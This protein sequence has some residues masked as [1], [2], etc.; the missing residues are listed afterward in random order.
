MADKT[1]IS[2]LEAQKGKELKALQDEWKKQISTKPKIV[3]P[4]DGKKYSPDSYFAYDGFFPGY[5]AQ[6]K[7]VLFI[8]RETRWISGYNFVDTTIDFFKNINVAGSAWWRTILY[9]FYGIQHEGKLSYA[10]IPTA[11]EIAKAMLTTNDFG[12]AVMQLSKYS[13]DSDDGAT[14]NVAL[15]N[16]FLEDSELDKRNFF[17]EEL[18]LLDPDIIITANLWEAGVD[19]KYM[20]QCFPEEK[21]K[22]WKSYKHGIAEYGEYDLN[23]KAV[24]FINTYHFSAHKPTEDCFYKPVMKILFPKK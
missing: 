2:K 20:E 18:A 21:F 12:F 9:I 3:F 17:Q 22:S 14:R 15:M 5:F 19:E 6:K 11:D 16:R 7:K 1:N 23:G 24:Q 8:G 4:D 10:E 13:N